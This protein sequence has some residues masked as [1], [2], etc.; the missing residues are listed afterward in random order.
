MGRDS[1][2]L[3]LIIY[4]SDIPIPFIHVLGL[5]KNVWND[6]INVLSKYFKYIVFNLYGRGSNHNLAF[7]IAFSM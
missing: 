5:N 4:G 7:L 3:K 2:K 1:T 6:V